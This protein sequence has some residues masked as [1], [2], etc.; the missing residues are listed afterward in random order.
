MSVYQI[1]TNKILD[2]L[3]R[4]IVPWK[5]PYIGVPHQNFFTRRPYSGI[6]S[7]LLNID[8]MEFNYESPY[9]LT[10][11]QI[12]EKGWTIKKGAKS[13]IV[14]FWSPVNVNQT[15][16][17]DE[18]NQK[19]EKTRFVFRYYRVFNTSQINELPLEEVT[20]KSKIESSD[21][22]FERLKNY[23]Q[24]EKI[25]LNYA[26]NGTSSYSVLQDAITLAPVIE[27]EKVP[28]FCHECIHSTGHPNRLNRIRDDT[29]L[30][31]KYSMEELIAE[32]G[33]S[34]LCNLLGIT[35]NNI[36]QSVSYID[37]WLKFLKDDRKHSVISAS[38]QAQKAVDYI[39]KVLNI[40]LAA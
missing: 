21:T 12:N 36:D 27:S 25:T 11:N 31:E 34:M 30:K 10:W 22:N 38:S 39:L 19:E 8:T 37:S 29:Y 5:N 28:I 20:V 24:L 33:S 23:C 4:K 40:S 13:C 3:E 2:A 35:E 17:N 14:T 18:D 15:I 6:N 7:L 32:I 9:W 1:V 16:D 26:V